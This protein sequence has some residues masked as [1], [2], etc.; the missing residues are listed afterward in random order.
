[1][2]ELPIGFAA[3]VRLDAFLF[4][5]P[6]SAADWSWHRGPDRNGISTETGWIDCWPPAGARE[7]PSDQSLVL[8]SGGHDIQHA[9]HAAA[10]DQVFECTTKGVGV[11]RAARA[12]LGSAVRTQ[13]SSSAVTP[14]QLLFWRSYRTRQTNSCGSVKSLRLNLELYSG[15][16]RRATS[17]AATGIFRG[18]LEISILHWLPAEGPAISY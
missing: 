12:D 17:Y 14:R 6:A 4:V 10:F 18:D 11:G 3:L 5:R 15:I 13:S 9:V 16:N 7:T 1:M 8:A 2:R